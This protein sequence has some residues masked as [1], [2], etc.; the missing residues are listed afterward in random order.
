MALGGALYFVGPALEKLGTV[1][2]A[3]LS[4]MGDIAKG[5]GDIFSGIGNV[6]VTHILAIAGAMSTL[7]SA[8]TDLLEIDND[9][10]AALTGV[11][12]A[13]AG[14][15]ANMENFV[16]SAESLK[17]LEGVVKVSAQLDEANVASFKAIMQ[18]TAPPQTAAAPS[19]R[20]PTKKMTIPINFNIDDTMISSYV[21]NVVDTKFDVTRIK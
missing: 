11:L 8:M 7:K 14:A 15:G 20:S 5:V 19:T 21:V 4:A 13:L 9:K 2:V 3:G 17:A 6:S 16:A 18:A 10:A 1:F 12:G